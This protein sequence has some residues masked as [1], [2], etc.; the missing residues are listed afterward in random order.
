ML[1]EFVCGTLPYGNDAKDP[2]A[3]YN[4]ILETKLKY[5]SFVND[6]DTQAV[7]E[8]LL[9][10]NPSERSVNDG[11]TGI[12]KMNFFDRIEWDQIAKGKC[13]GPYIPKKF[14]NININNYYK[15]LRG[16]P[17]LTEFYK[18][19]GTSKN[20]EGQT[21]KNIGATNKKI[22]FTNK[23]IGLTNK[24]IGFTNKNIGLT[25]KNIGFRTNK[26]VGGVTNK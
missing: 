21:S 5:P 14:R 4:Q 16:T 13:L 22:G 7:I 3:V 1:Y 11:F 9:S 18:N 17:F 12:K 6:P 10:K 8:V 15:S 19:K 23:N 25:N 26:N 24:N 2:Y 20:I